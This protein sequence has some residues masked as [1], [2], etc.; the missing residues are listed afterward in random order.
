M[1]LLE[2]WRGIAAR[3]AGL[4][5]LLG[6]APDRGLEPGSR[7][8]LGADQDERLIALWEAG[9]RRAYP[10]STLSDPEL[11]LRIA[12]AF[13]DARNFYSATDPAATARGGRRDEWLRHLDPEEGRRFISIIYPEALPDGLDLLN[14]SGAEWRD[15]SGEG[16]PTRATYLD[17]MESGVADAAAA[18]TLVLDFWRGRIGETELAEGIG[19]GSLSLGGKHGK[20]RAPLVSSPLPLDRVMDAE[21]ASH[22]DLR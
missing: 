2:R 14:E 9:L 13:C 12:N 19:Q 15:P 7:D 10:R 11:R 8:Y 17:L 18:I 4:S 1:A 3:A 22:V 21:Y 20:S 5:S 16:G 6:L